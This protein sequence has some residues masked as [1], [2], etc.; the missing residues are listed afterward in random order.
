MTISGTMKLAILTARAG[1]MRAGVSRASYV[2]RDTVNA[3]GN[4][5]GGFVRYK[6]VYVTPIT[7]TV[8]KT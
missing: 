1:Q 3:A 8:V 6:R 2:P 4:G 5:V 7:Y